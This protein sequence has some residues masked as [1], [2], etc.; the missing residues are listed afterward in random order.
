MKKLIKETR[1]YA[2][3][4][5]LPM[6]REVD[7]KHVQKMI[8]SVRTMGI[9]RPVVTCKTS[10]LD[11]I[12][13]TYM[14]D[15]QHL[16]TALERED[17]PVPYIEIKVT[18]EVDIVN[19]MAML[20]NSSKSWTLLNYIGAYKMYYPDYMK[21]FKW[22]NLYNIEPLM[23]ACIGINV[24]ADIASASRL[25]KSGDFKITNPD[26]EDMCKAF[27]ELFIKVG[28]ADR[29]IK[30][31]FLSVFLSVYSSYDHE[32]ALVNIDK[33][34]KRIKTMSDSS[35]AEIFIRKKIFK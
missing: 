25:I 1:N 28:S 34:I 27:N 24:N 23:L 18:D 31:Q 33:H 14:L 5:I 16:A 22:K 10:C 3:L 11:G 29:W 12:T 15:G 8:M 4:H 20:N 7:S 21:L 19:K 26:A 6:N 32:K 30:K 35:A 13:K 2:S 9:I 17:K